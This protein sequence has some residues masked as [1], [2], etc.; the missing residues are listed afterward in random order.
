MWQK[1]LADSLFSLI[2]KMISML[3]YSKHVRLNTGNLGNAHWSLDKK[4]FYLNS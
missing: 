3:A 1:Y 2:S 4:T